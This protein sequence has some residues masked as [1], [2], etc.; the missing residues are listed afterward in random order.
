MTAL[1]T[2]FMAGLVAMTTVCGSSDPLFEVVRLETIYARGCSGDIVE[3][4]DGT[5]L[6]A[7]HPERR[8]PAVCDAPWP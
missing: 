6:F 1:R 3:L 7:T 2:L 8:N 5:L 4:K